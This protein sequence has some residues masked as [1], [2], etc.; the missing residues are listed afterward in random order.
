MAGKVSPEI[1][2]DLRNL[3]MRIRLFVQ[4][5][6]RRYARLTAVPAPF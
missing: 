5:V 2:I 3:R 4:P 1:R 6:S